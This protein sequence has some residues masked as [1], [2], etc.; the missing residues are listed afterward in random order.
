MGNASMQ[1]GFVMENIS[2]SSTISMIPMIQMRLKVA[3]FIQVDNI[4]L[5]DKVVSY[6]STIKSIYNKSS[7]IEF[8]SHQK[9]VAHLIRETSMLNVQMV[10]DAFLR[11]LSTKQSI[12]RILMV[13]HPAAK[14]QVVKMVGNA[15]M[16]DV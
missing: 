12:A 11:V 8:L 15:M 10:T 1:N 2:V 14:Q 3:N 7:H 13:Q 6:K 16:D 9:L 5:D 4:N